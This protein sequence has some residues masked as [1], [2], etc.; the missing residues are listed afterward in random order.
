MEAC[1]GLCSE[2]GIPATVVKRGDPEAGAIYLKI[3][4]L[5]NNCIVLS[6]AYDV[7]GV[8]YWVKAC[9]GIQITEQEADLFIE[10]Q[11]KYDN[12]IWVLEVEDKL[13]RNPYG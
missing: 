12:D 9:G 2:K 10:R 6:Q 3:N 1:L 4:G 5:E 13:L 11:I 7:E 8:L